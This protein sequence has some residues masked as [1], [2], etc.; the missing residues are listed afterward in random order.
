MLSVFDTPCQSRI[1][2]KFRSMKIL[3]RKG[4]WIWEDD[5]FKRVLFGTTAV[6]WHNNLKSFPNNLFPYN[7]KTAEKFQFRKR[8]FRESI[9][10]SLYQF[11]NRMF[12]EFGENDSFLKSFCLFTSENLHISIHHK[13]FFLCYCLLVWWWIQANGWLLANPPNKKTYP[14]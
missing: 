13:M 4:S 6:T 2:M 10:I 5:K 9:R 1:W 3:F 11:N 14:L 8:N 12:R 7:S